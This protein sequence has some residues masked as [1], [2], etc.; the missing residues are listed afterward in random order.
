MNIGVCLKRVP[1]SET[2]IRINGDGSGIATDDVKWIVNPYDE[3]ALEAALQ[4]KEAKLASSVVILTVGDAESEKQ[5]KDGLARGADSAIRLDDPAFAGSDALGY[6]RVLAAA[7]K[8]ADIGLLLCGRSAIDGDSSQVPA[9][10]AELLGWPQVT[11]V[12][13]LELADGK[14]TCHRAMG[15]GNVDVVSAP[16]PAV[17]TCDKGLNTPRFASLRGIMMAKKKKV[18]V[19]GAGDIGVDASQVGA[20]AANVVESDYALP[21]A[22]PSGRIIDG[23]S[24]EAKAKELVRLLREEAK[25]I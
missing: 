10:V 25:V 19:W 6:A 5:I 16:L 24:A 1:D 23:D 3:Y 15:G 14:L 12:E 8:K 22:R 13:G 18:T 9:M 20:G 11:V 2:R 4:M 21:P 7:A 17:V